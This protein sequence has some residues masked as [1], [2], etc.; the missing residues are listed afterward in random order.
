M[1]TMKQSPTDYYKS[2]TD[3][4]SVSLKKRKDKTKY[5][6][7]AEIALFLCFVAG[8]AVLFSDCEEAMCWAI[9][10]CCAFFAVCFILV[11]RADRKN[12]DEVDVLA[13]RISVCRDEMEYLSGK[14]DSFDDGKRYIDPDHQYTYDMDVF[15]EKSLYQRICRAVTT[16]GADR[17]AEI[18]SSAALGN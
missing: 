16:G 7:A 12:Q 10:I 17:L 8:V 9:Y 6:I 3:E 14:L 11:K 5:F 13:S 1:I 4:M 15:G 18:L 2:K